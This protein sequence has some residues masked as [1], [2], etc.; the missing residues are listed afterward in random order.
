M[1]LRMRWIVPSLILLFSV[2]AVSA[3]KKIAD[4]WVLKP[5][6]RPA[7]PVGVTNSKN[8]IDAFIQARLLDEG[9]SPSPEAD[10]RTLIRRV[11]LDL[12][13][14]APTPEQT[15][16]FVADKSPQAYEQLVDRLLDSPA[17]AEKQAVRWLD[18]VR[19]ADTAGFHSDGECD[20]L[21]AV[22]LL[23]NPC[24]PA[25]T[26]SPTRFDPPAHHHAMRRR[27]Y[28]PTAPHCHP[29]ASA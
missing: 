1:S 12:T 28:H 14:L 27:A 10:R 19:Y 15:A 20:G 13:G 3:P 7:V 2:A 25:A 21:R 5:V 8:P 29:A 18:A 23:T 17:Y 11:T 24:Q 16:A 22:R 26:H 9:L 6:V 4:L